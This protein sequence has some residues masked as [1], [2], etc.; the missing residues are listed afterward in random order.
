MDIVKTSDAVKEL[1]RRWDNYAKLNDE[2]IIEGLLEM[3]RLSS[4]SLKLISGLI[5]R[6]RYKNTYGIVSM[7]N[8]SLYTAPAL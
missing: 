1:M 6:L 4:H 5:T 2:A 7:D 8:A 3:F